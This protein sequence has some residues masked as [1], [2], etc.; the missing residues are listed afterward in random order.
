MDT[1]QL[2]K[3]EH[4][5]MLERMCKYLYTILESKLKATMS[6]D[7]DDFKAFIHKTVRFCFHQLGDRYP[8]VREKVDLL[9]FGAIKEEMHKAMGEILKISQAMPVDISGLQG[10]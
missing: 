5:Y 10:F 8:A 3:V 4:R 9:T 6:R 1:S 7:K 2:T